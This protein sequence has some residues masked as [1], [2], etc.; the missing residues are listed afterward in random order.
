[1]P[2]V[3]SGVLKP[4]LEENPGQKILTHIKRG[5]DEGCCL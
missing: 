2:C 5:F 1:M 3:I 4:V